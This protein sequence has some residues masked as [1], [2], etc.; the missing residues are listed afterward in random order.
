MI[1]LLKRPLWLPCGKGVEGSHNGSLESSEELLQRSEQAV[2]VV[3][4]GQ[5]QGFP[6]EYMDSGFMVE[7]GPRGLSHAKMLRHLGGSQEP[8]V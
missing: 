7:V 2:M 6:R 1:S 3:H 5:R 8:D 4:G